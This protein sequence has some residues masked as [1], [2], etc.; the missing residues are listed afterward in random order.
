M[1]YCDIAKEHK[2]ELIALL[3]ELVQIDS[4]YDASTISN[5]A[6]FGKGI[7]KTVYLVYVRRFKR[8]SSFL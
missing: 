3:K 6:P 2:S 4:V 5:G 1:N 7:K 8:Y